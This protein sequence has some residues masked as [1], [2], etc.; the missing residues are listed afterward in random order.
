MPRPQANARR[1]PASG[2]A[3]AASIARRLRGPPGH[4]TSRCANVPGTASLGHSRRSRSAAIGP[5]AIPAEPAT[6]DALRIFRWRSG[7]ARS[8]RPNRRAH[9]SSRTRSD[10]NLGTAFTMSRRPG[11]TAL[12]RT[13]P[14]MPVVDPGGPPWSRGVVRRSRPYPQQLPPPASSTSHQIRWIGWASSAASLETT[15]SYAPFK[16]F[17]GGYAGDDRGPSTDTSVTAKIRRILTVNFE[18][19]TVIPRY[20]RVCPRR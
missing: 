8:S 4:L 12:F 15:R 6:P 1:R 3:F 9:R 11:P 10:G 16:R 7:S 2:R 20:A 17:G 19:L 18:R 5:A 14:E 13:D